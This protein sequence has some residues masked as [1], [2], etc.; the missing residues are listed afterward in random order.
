MFF[1]HHAATETHVDRLEEVFRSLGKPAR[2]ANC[3]AIVG[4]IEDADGLLAETDD[5]E[6]MDAALMALAQA[7]E[8]HEI[9][10]D[11]TLVAK[12]TRLGHPEAATLLKM[13]LDEENAAA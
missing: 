12:A 13:T 3:D 10:R 2:G 4:L 6:T 1:M 8:H 9:A 5:P 7:A 11:G